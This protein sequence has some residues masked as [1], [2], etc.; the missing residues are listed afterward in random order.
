MVCMV[1]AGFWV[2]SVP[3]SLQTLTLRSPATRSLVQFV[4]FRMQDSNG[5]PTAGIRTSGIGGCYRSSV[6]GTPY[7]PDQHPSTSKQSQYP[8]FVWTSTTYSNTNCI[9]AAYHTYG[10]QGTSMVLGNFCATTYSSAYYYAGYTTFGSVRCVGFRVH[11]ALGR[12]Y[13]ILS[14]AGYRCK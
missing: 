6:S 2:G 14:V 4:G 7:C 5:L 9:G 10:L 12:V 11:F 8:S 1:Q 13:T 3:L